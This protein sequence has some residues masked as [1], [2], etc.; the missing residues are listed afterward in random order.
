V[1]ANLDAAETCFEENDPEGVAF[2]YEVLEDLPAVSYKQRFL[3]FSVAT[4][5]LTSQIEPVLR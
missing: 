2:E 3:C 4:G 5:F 1:F